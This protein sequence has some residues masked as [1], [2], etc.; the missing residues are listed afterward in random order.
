MNLEGKV[1]IVTGSGRGLGLAYAKR[2]A[3]AGAQVL[4]NDIDA[5][6]A[7]E[8][9]NEIEQRVA[10]RSQRSLPWE[11]ARQRS[12]SSIAPSMSLGAWT[13]W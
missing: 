11:V 10:L 6:V 3:V 9:V 5:E 1:A 8:A 13:F 7:N 2:L 4:V 12:S